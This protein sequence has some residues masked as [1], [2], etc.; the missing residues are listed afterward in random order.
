ML[1]FRVGAMTEVQRAED[2]NVEDC[3]LAFGNVGKKDSCKTCST[4]LTSKS[5]IFRAFY[6]LHPASQR[7]LPKRL[8]HA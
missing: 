3:V 5:H 8:L 6:Y 7:E 4:S 1:K 2:G